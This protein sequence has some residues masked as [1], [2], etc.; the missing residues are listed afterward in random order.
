MAL[1]Q[2][3]RDVVLMLIPYCEACATRKLGILK[4]FPIARKDAQDLCRHYKIKAYRV[5]CECKVADLP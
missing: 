3:S 1:V 2:D 4:I 5:G